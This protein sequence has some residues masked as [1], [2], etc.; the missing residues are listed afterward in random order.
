[1]VGANSLAEAAHCEEMMTLHY[2][3]EITAPIAGG[4]RL[5]SI[6]VWLFPKAD[7]PKN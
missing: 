2:R 7:I 3:H 6:T 1:V 5:G 4:Q